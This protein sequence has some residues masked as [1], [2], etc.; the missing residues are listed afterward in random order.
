[1]R[2]S[3]EERWKFVSRHSFVT[4]APRQRPWCN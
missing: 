1:L 3:V 2:S 4:L